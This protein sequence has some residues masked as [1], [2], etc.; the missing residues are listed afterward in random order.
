MKHVSSSWETDNQIV[1]NLDFF[2]ESEVSLRLSSV[3]NQL[4]P[5]YMQYFL[6]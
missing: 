5:L 6:L 4:N 1:K 2:T 3:Q